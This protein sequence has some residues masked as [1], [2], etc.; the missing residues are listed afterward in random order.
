M[1]RPKK[2][3]PNHGDLYEIKINFSNKGEPPDRRSFYSSISKEDARAKGMQAKAEY[4][5]KRMAGLPDVKKGCPF[6]V[7]ARKWL[8]VY[9][10]PNTTA[11]GFAYTYQ[12]SVEKHLIPYFGSTLLTNIRHVDIQ[13][14]FDQ[15]KELSQS[16]LDKIHLCLNGIFET[17]IENDLCYKNPVKRVAYKSSRLPNQKQTLSPEQRD[18]VIKMADGIMDEI[19]V[20]LNTGIRRGEL[21]ALRWDDINTQNNTIEIC[22]SVAD[23][24]RNAS[25]HEFKRKITLMPPKWNSFRTIPINSTVM[26]II[27][28]QPHNGDFIFSNDN[29]P[30]SPNTWGQKLAR[31]MIQVHTSDP[32]IPILTAHE[33][34]HTYG[35]L[36]RRA[37]VDIYTIQK[38]LGHRDIKMTTEIYV[39]NEI[40]VLRSALKLDS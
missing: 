15:K 6:D 5:A 31:F 35:T 33:L 13:S 25:A 29:E 38:L 27:Q 14:F 12:N 21:L 4:L 20:I 37:G 16:M 17:A 34:R 24:P 40:E 18:K 26:D 11:A 8:E 9:K 3:K 7:W 1:P 22:H 23:L 32:T 39:H 36:L 28:R 30:Q 2:E 10:K 19:I